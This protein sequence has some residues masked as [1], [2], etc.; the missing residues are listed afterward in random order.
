[1][2]KELVEAMKAAG[3]DPNKCENKA[4]T[5]FDAV[6]DYC[7]RNHRPPTTGDASRLCSLNGNTVGDLL[8]RLTR[9]GR[10]IRINIDGRAH[11]LPKVKK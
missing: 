1:M 11:W 2:D 6:A 3:V 9:T 4:D 10:I 8:V 7:R 5:V